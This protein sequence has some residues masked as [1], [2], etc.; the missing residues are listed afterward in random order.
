M[1]RSI[2]QEDL[3]HLVSI[4]E[5]GL[6]VESFP[7]AERPVQRRRQLLFR[8]ALVEWEKQQ[9]VLE[10]KVERRTKRID[11]ATNE[12]YQLVALYS[13]FVG[14]VYTAVLQST[15]VQCKH[16]WSPIILCS[17]AYIVILSVTYIKFRDINRDQFTKEEDD[18]SR[19]VTQFHF[20]LPSSS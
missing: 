20:E 1:E 17:V 14:V 5:D 19:Q 7:E 2:A 3:E 4:K 11:Q 6:Y 15:R 8:E 18:A 10:G 13:V 12:I 9:K 16:I